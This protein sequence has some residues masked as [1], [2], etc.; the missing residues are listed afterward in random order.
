MHTRNGGR[1]G[2]R[3]AQR[4]RKRATSNTNIRIDTLA[5]FHR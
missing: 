1:T 2:V 5:Q 4:R 3:C